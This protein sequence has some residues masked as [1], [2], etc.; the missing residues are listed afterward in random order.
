MWGSLMLS[1]RNQILGKDMVFLKFSF[2]G[3]DDTKISMDAYYLIKELRKAKIIS[4]PAQ[5]RSMFGCEMK[6]AADD[7]RST[8]HQLLL[9]ERFT[10]RFMPVQHILQNCTI[11]LARGRGIYRQGLILQNALSLERNS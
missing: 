2:D 4:F 11:Y 7:K 1:L 5:L 10:P 3:G 6:K 9:Y 8:C